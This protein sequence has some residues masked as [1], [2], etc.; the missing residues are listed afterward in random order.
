MRNNHVNR[1]FGFACG[2]VLLIC[3]APSAAQAQTSIE[4]AKVRKRVERFYTYFSQH[5][6]DRMW[7][8]LSTALKEG[9]DNNKSRYVKEL[10]QA[11]LLSMRFEIT[12][13]KIEGSR[14][15]ATVVM[16]I[17]SDAAADAKT[18]HEE[19]HEDVWVKERGIWLFDGSRLLSENE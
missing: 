17:H 18:T 4:E 6:Y 9:N 13:L 12:A 8:M 2:L 11:R 19:T 5:K 1:G 10:N 7:P 15:T 14:A 16:R 3:A